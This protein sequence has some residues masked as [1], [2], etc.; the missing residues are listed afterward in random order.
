MLSENLA[1]ISREWRSE[2]KVIVYLHENIVSQDRSRVMQAVVGR[3]WVTS[4]SEISSENAKNRF[5]EIFPSL[6]DLMNDWDEQPLPASLE[7][8]FD[9]E[10]V[11]SSEFRGWV[12]ELRALS[13]VLMVDDDR[14][15]LSRLDT[16][17]GVLRGI[18][19]G[20]GLLLLG[21]AVFTIASVI[22]L[23][24][25]LYRDE[26]MV[27]RLVGAT[28]LYIRGPFYVEGLT[29]GLVGGFGALLGLLVAFHSFKPTEATALLGTVFIG[30]FLG[31]EQ[32]VILILLGGAAGLF[33]AILSLR[34]ESLADLDS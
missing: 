26:I 33:G 18:G 10:Q 19:L 21:A 9:A 7:A 1:R 23:T 14:D 34:R 25:Y 11:S 29:Q 22:R 16:L 2:A 3:P 27:M 6:A 28:E 31:F 4:V 15:W 5:Q 20:L 17:I 24:S 13:G 12:G 30:D 8:S 32:I